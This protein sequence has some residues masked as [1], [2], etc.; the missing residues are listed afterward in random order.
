[1]T[2]PSITAAYSAAF[3]F[4]FF[5]LAIWVIAGRLNSGI[6]HGDG[7]QEQMNRRI[8]AHGNFAEYVPMIL[9]LAA[10]LEAGGTG[11]TTMHAFLAPLLI[12]RVLHPFGMLAP[13]GSVRQYVCRG[14]GIMV[15]LAVLV[16]EAVRLALRMA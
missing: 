8:R 3:A 1:M 7:G 15:T 13:V 16:A 6:L 4:L 2:Y 9:L 5:V 10:L 12:A 14:G 11:P